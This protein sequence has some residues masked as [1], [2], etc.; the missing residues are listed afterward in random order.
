MSPLAVLAYE[1]LLPGSQ[2]VNRLR[3]LGYRVLVPAQPDDLPALA[4]QEL[5]LVILIDLLVKST[6]AIE[7][8]KALR[9]NAATAHIPV[10]AFGPLKQRA[11]LNSASRAGAT[12]IA[13]S[14]GICEQL[15]ALLTQVLEVH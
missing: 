11:L 3:E 1:A 8:I 4:D 14:D 12:L 10:I 9:A 5:P 2:L 15:P 7:C 13:V 6:D